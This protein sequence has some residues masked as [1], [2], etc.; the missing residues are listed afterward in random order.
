MNLMFSSPFSRS[1]FLPLRF[2]NT[3]SSAETRKLLK[4]IP[5]LPKHEILSMLADSGIQVDSMKPLFRYPY[6]FLGEWDVSLRVGN[7][8]IKQAYE[9]FI[10]FRTFSDE[11]RQPPNQRYDRHLEMNPGC[12]IRVQT[13]VTSR[14]AIRDAFP[15]TELRDIEVLLWSQTPC[16]LLVFPSPAA[17]QRALFEGPKVISPASSNMTLLP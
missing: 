1:C 12:V 11:G 13:D 6:V 4:S 10:T 14:Q 5:S 2:I 3:T 16:V 8:A 15:Y 7:Q 9:P 17:A